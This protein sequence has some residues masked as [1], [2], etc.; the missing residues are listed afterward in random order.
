MSQ[1]TVKIAVA[2]RRLEPRVDAAERAAAG[3]DVGHHGD[4]ERRVQLGR[5]RHD[6]QIVGDRGQDVHDAVDDAPAAELHQGFGLAPHARAL[7]AGLDH[8]A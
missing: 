5:I 4:A 7:A 8:P 6:Q 2:R 1:A 3:E